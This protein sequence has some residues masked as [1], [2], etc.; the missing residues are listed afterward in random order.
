M[1]YSENNVQH[2]RKLYAACVAATEQRIRTIRE[3]LAALAEAKNSET[4]SSVG[5]KYETGRAM[6]Q[7]EE[8]KSKRQLWDALQTRQVLERIDPDHAS[9]T[10]RAGSLVRTDQG[11]YYVAIGIGKVTLD[12]EVY[13]CVSAAAPLVK[14]ML[15]K[16]AGDEVNFNGTVRKIEAVR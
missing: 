4:K 12:G 10:V 16:Q 1:S 15:G 6:L 14:A 7:I 3:T 8:E 13:Y 2:K 11:S 5:D 9:A